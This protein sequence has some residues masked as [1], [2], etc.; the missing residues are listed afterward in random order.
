MPTRRVKRR[1]LVRSSDCSKGQAGGIAVLLNPANRI[2]MEGIIQALRERLRT[3]HHVLGHMRHQEPAQHRTHHGPGHRNI[4]TRPSRRGQGRPAA[5]HQPHETSSHSH[6]HG[7]DRH[8]RNQAP[9]N[10]GLT[11]HNRRDS[12]QGKSQQRRIKNTQTHRNTQ[13]PAHRIAGTK[14]QHDRKK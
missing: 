3:I 4:V 11:Q 8:K 1:L 12:H 7:S 13:R 14:S 2:H 9:R 5:A 6:H 10:A